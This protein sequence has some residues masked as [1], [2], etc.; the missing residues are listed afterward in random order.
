[1]D[2]G[3]P[4]GGE[5]PIHQRRGS[6]SRDCA[7]RH[8]RQLPHETIASG[9]VGSPH[10]GHSTELCDWERASV[11]RRVVDLADDPIAGG[12]R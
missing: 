3:S 6:V 11:A 5:T 12:G 1:M 7:A 9:V 4:A 10:A 8:A 2:A